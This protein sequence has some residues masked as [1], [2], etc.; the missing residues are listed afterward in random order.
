MTVYCRKLPVGSD[1]EGI[2]DIEDIKL[3]VDIE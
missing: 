3:P 2:Y 1:P